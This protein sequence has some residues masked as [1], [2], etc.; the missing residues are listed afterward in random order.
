MH[1]FMHISMASLKIHGILLLAAVL[2]GLFMGILWLLSAPFRTS[3]AKGKIGELRVRRIA[4][5]GL[6][7]RTY[8]R[9]HD[10]M[11]KTPDGT[12][13]IDHLFLSRFGV[14]VVETKNWGGWLFGREGDLHW[15]QMI[16]GETFKFLN[17]LR[18]NYKHV[19]AVKT[20]L[21]IPMDKIH[22]VVALVGRCAFKTPIPSGVTMGSGFI[23]Y[24]KLF[25]EPV[26]TQHEVSLLLKRIE[27]KRLAS[28]RRRRRIHVLNLKR[29]SDPNARWLCPKCG[30]PMILRTVKQGSRVGQRFWGCSGYPQCRF[31]RNLS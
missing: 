10:V 18:Q 15:T 28:T 19:R 7:W 26:F 20:A 16:E 21:D 24:I 30:R 13:Q 9:F 31:T 22:P 17:P 12:T 27:A 6:G 29:R 5:F 4:W 2:L 11:L 1:L 8:Y 3:W 25:R 14:F 23:R